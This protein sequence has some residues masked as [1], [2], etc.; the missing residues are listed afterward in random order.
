MIRFILTMI[1]CGIALLVNAQEE[2]LKFKGIPITGDIGSFEIKLKECGFK[3]I[4]HEND[5][6]MMEGSFAGKD[7]AK[8]IVFASPKTHTTCRIYVLLDVGTTWNS[9]KTAYSN[10]VELFK[11]KYGKPRDNIE[12]FSRPYYEGDGYEL[13]AVR[14]EKCHYITGFSVPLGYISVSISNNCK[15]KIVYEDR[16]NAQIEVEERKRSIIDDI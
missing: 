16:K 3:E 8:I 12:L 1:V 13:Q 2:H 4:L 6:F 10:Y 11:Y 14:N 5:G 9:L 7:D 15:I